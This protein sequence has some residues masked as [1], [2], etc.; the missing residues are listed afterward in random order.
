MT[1]WVT[2]A[3][4]AKLAAERAAKAA[5]EV[6]DLEMF[7]QLHNGTAT[8]KAAAERVQPSAGSMRI[9][10]LR[11]LM[12]NYK[13]LTR[14]EIVAE[15]GLIENTVNARCRELV[16]TGLAYEDGERDGRKVVHITAAGLRVLEAKGAA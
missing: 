10:V 5:Q 13:G 11:A 3:V 4:R 1:D 15:A 9:D 14:S 12:F 7:R 2:D 6:A 16:E 8:S